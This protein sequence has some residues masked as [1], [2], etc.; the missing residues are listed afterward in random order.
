MV[1]PTRA[2]NLGTAVPAQQLGQHL[3][4]DTPLVVPVGRVLHHLGVGAERG[5]VHER[6]VTDEAEVDPLFYAVAGEGGQAG[7]RI[8]AVQPEVHR[9]VVAG[10]RADDQEREIMLGGDPGYQGLRP[11]AS[12]HAEQV[13]PGSDRLPGQLRHVHDAWAFEQHHLS[14]Q[15]LGLLLQP[16]LRH[17]PVT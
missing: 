1:S 5:V 6:P 12:R 7:R 8:V 3:Q 15:C 14:P 2:D 17:L 9:E 16:E 11:V 10:A 13:R 4:G